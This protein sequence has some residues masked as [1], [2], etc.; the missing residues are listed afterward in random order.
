M[1]R[2]YTTRMKKKKKTTPVRDTVN[3]L[4]LSILESNYFLICRG[5]FM[6]IP[7]N[8]LYHNNTR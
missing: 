2:W 1:T 3:F 7:N 4:F 5:V 8:I 6:Y